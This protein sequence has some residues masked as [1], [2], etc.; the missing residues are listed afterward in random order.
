MK[1]LNK[2]NL[3]NENV[4]QAKALLKKI[5]ISE[6]DPDFIKIK[7]MLKGHDG[8]VYWF[9][10]LRFEDNQPVDELKNIWN[11]INDNNGLIN[12][13]T[14]KVVDL[15]SIE[16]FWDQYERAKLVSGAKKVL[17]QFP[18]NQKR[19][20]KL[21][22]EEDF[23]LLVS[24]SK[25][26]SL[27][28]LIRKISSFRDKATLVAA[29]QRLLTSSFEGKF[30]EL[31][32]LINSV[33]ADIKV[34]DEENNI[35]ICGVNYLQIKKLGGDTSWCIVSSEGTFNSYASGGFQWVIFLVDNFGKNEK[36]SK[37]GFT[38]HFGYTTAH[39][40]YDG[41]IPKNT[42]ENILSERGVDIKDFYISR[43]NLQLMSNWDLVPVEILLDKKFTKEEIIKKKN[44]F[45][46]KS[47]YNRQ[48]TTKGDIEYFT[49]EEI[50]K[51]NIE[52][53]LEI[54]WAYISKLD[55]KDII[56]RKLFNRLDSQVYLRNLTDSLKFTK[57][58]ILEN[59]IY[60]SPKIIILGN[61]LFD[62]NSS[63]FVFSKEEIIKY[64]LINHI[65][66]GVYLDSLFRNG[67]T[68]EEVIKLELY[69]SN[70]VL[71]NSETLSYFKKDEL[72]KL[73][74]IDKATNISY[75]ILF[76]AGFTKSEI[77]KKY[78]N[79]LDSN[80][81]NVIEFF[82][83]KTKIGIKNRL[84]ETFWRD[85]KEKLGIEDNL[86]YKV[87]L[88]AMSL[89]DINFEM[90]GMNGL[91]NIIGNSKLPCDKSNLEILSSL[92]FKITDKDSFDS[93]S[94]VFSINDNNS[95]FPKLTSILKFR[96]LFE[97]D[98]ESYEFSTKLL[99][100]ALRGDLYFNYFDLIENKNALMGPDY[101]RIIKALKES[102]LKRYSWD[103]KT[104]PSKDS[105]NWGAAD[106]KNTAAFMK[107]L[108]FTKEDIENMGIEK[109]ANIFEQSGSRYA[110]DSTYDNIDKVV[111]LLTEYGFEITQK[112]E[113]KIIRSIIR[114]SIQT[115]SADKTIYSED[116]HKQ[117]IKRGFNLDDSLESL[118]KYFKS[119]NKLTSYE[120][121]DYLECFEK[122]GEEWVDK[123][124]EELKKV[125]KR[126]L[127]YK[128]LKDLDE[129]FQRPN[130]SQLT[131]IKWYEEYFEIYKDIHSGFHRDKDKNDIMVIWLL[132]KLNKLDEID[133]F[134]DMS[135]IMS[136][137]RG[138]TFDDN[139]LHSIAKL[140]CKA[141]SSYD[142][143]FKYV[144]LSDEQMKSFYDLVIS[145][146]DESKYW[147]KKYLSVCY[148]IYDK[149]KFDKFI[150]ELLTIKDNYK[151]RKYDRRGDF[152]ED[153]IITLRIDGL[154]YILKKFARENKTSE[155]ESLVN[156]IVFHRESSKA[157]SKM[158]K[159]EFDLT[160][161]AIDNINGNNS[162]D[163]SNW[164]DNYI[165][166]LQDKFRGVKESFIIKWIDF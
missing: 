153:S 90:I 66:Y 56:N 47:K 146:V 89:Y 14:K 108:K 62:N 159:T 11:I 79:I 130:R 133:S 86:L 132:I 98:D 109:F 6:S 110:S 4:A 46:D 80:T 145:N 136:E 141:D 120:E 37:I 148:Y 69:K 32:K 54:T 166:E 75:D 59:E 114:G 150:N 99:D 8:Y 93:I 74:I 83:G 21:D 34:A 100:N 94:S 165:K 106:F 125:K 126:E 87:K 104:K 15:D 48:S 88:I 134:Y 65:T 160:L 25:S 107:E 96:N 2:F 7:D 139:I 36:M 44:L 164:Q 5:K 72:I 20:L 81:R 129:V 115:R 77:I 95:T 143:D 84:R 71:I 161:K 26:K 35:I 121:K 76:S 60:K 28:A 116:Y 138:F 102:K 142:R 61:E 117:L 158:K 119:N 41:Y 64:D 92:G 18:A 151:L 154:R 131:P 144:E 38:T 163:F 23:N 140:L 101:D 49:E 31:L 55:K 52:D 73:G 3:V 22:N 58:E 162:R 40:K 10:K 19:F 51:W 149:P 111:N 45:K 50:K 16:S 24:L 39:D 105:D 70:K 63:N 27:P 53:R 33:D 85:D 29:A 43:E 128:C 127:Y 97:I 13:F 78:S 135:R 156:K 82:K 68:K 91:K 152:K 124:K 17:N 157:S 42:L 30:G 122:G 112:D 9:T 67:F 12:Y 123:F 103:L 118:F 147:V 137:G 1:Y 155:I 113:I 57:E